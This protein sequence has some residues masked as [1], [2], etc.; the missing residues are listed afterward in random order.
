MIVLPTVGVS[1]V[2]I[3]KNKEKRRATMS[4]I[5]ERLQEHSISE[6]GIVVEGGG[7]GVALVLPIPLETASKGE[8]I[9]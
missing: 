3:F 9:Y 4:V 7:G 8:D 6:D 1:S 2:F 5:S